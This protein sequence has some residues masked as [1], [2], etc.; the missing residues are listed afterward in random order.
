MKKRGFTLIE[1][2]VVIAIIGIL[3][4][5]VLV[6]MGGARSKARDAQRQSDI[7]QVT[8]AQEMYYGDHDA[9]VTSVA[10]TGSVAIGTY[11][12]AINDPQYPTK[13]YVWVANNACSPAGQA[14]CVYATLENKGNCSSTQYF[15]ASEKGS[16]VICDS[17][18]NNGCSCY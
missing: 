12:A 7:R 3:A 17:V 2:L 18:P 5:V 13:T 10:A 11:L 6:S 4:S 16:K 9:Y 15:V 8:S 1:L 14:F